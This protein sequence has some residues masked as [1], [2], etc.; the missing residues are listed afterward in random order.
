MS[1]HSSATP[2]PFHHL[3]PIPFSLP[4]LRTLLAATVS[5]STV[6]ASLA[7]GLLQPAPLLAQSALLE[8]VK[9]N[10]ALAQN[11]CSQFKALN[12][13][14]KSATTKESFARVA[15]S[16]GVSPADG[17][18]VTLYVIGLYCPDVR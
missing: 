2:S 10:P 14:G 6:S 7:L 16:Q 13:Q 3:S 9:Q 11:L 1:R 4:P 8:S 12:A 5:A 18:V 15:A 17:E